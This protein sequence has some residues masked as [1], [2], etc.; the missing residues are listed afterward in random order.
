[1][2]LGILRSVLGQTDIYLL[3]QI[4]KGRYSEGMSILDAGCGQ[5]RNLSWFISQRINIYGIDQD[6][7]A[8]EEIKRQ[9][10]EARDN[11]SH[12]T[13]SQIP[14]A[15]HFFH[16]II[17]SAVLHFASDRKHFERLF[18]EHIRVLAPGGTLFIRM[19]SNI[20]LSSDRV[21]AI[22]DGVFKIPDGSV[23]FLITRK[24]ID[25]LLQQYDLSLMEPVKTTN[26]Q[27]Q[28]YMTT[29]LFQKRI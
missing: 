29:L 26:V 17:S 14:F 28:R 23:R 18:S 25:T 1:M 11:F 16:H 3:D 12:G 22:N 2:D 9:Y 5:G 15:D 4:L 13:L 27:D 20:G 21:T 19:T 24:M 7:E 6:S 10:P 8:I